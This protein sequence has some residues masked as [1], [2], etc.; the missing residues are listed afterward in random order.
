MKSEESANLGLFPY[1]FSPKY[2]EEEI[3]TQR[4]KIFQITLMNNGIRSQEE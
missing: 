4:V 1:N 3:E 2:T